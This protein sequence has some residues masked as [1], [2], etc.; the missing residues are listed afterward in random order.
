MAGWL[1]RLFASPRCDFQV[2]E[3]K[4][5]SRVHTTNA[6]QRYVPSRTVTRYMIQIVREREHETRQFVELRED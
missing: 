2:C 1:R 5:H 4:Y 6:G 3:N